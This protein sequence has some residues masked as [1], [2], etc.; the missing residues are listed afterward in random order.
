MDVEKIS[1]GEFGFEKCEALYPLCHRGPVDT[2]SFCHSRDCVRFCLRVGICQPEYMLKVSAEK[3][4]VLF[5]RD[6][7]ESGVIVPEYGKIECGPEPEYALWTYQN[8][9][10]GIF[11]LS[12]IIFFAS[13]LYG[14]YRTQKGAKCGNSSRSGQVDAKARC[15][16]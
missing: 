13:T 2:D 7:P 15:R 12:N 6:E 5:C 10:A 3:N 14:I 1:S 11:L 4:L 16:T 9:P 8:G